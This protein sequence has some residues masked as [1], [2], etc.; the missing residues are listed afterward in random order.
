MVDK[1]KET[2][3]WSMSAFVPKV[4]KKE[5]ALESLLGVVHMSVIGEGSCNTKFLEGLFQIIICPSSSHRILKN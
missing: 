3:L 2:N 5:T 4:G 1:E